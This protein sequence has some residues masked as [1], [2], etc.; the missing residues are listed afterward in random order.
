[1]KAVNHT[2]TTVK[3]KILEELNEDQQ[4]P[5]IDYHGPSFV[6]AG[7]G[8]GKTHTICS[9]A[10]YMIEEG[11]RPENMLIFT[12]TRKAAGELKE[13]IENKIGDK[14][15]GITIGTYHSV[16]SRL[17]RQYIHYLGFKNNFSIYDEEDK[18][19]LL[20]KIVTDDRIQHTTV[21]NYISDWKNRM[22]SPQ[23]AMV[24][25]QNTFEELSAGYYQKYQEQLKDQNALDF[26]DLIYQ[27]I[28]LLDNH[29]DVLEKVTNKYQYIMAE[30]IGR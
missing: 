2:L 28:R 27:T 11:V 21:A 5:V 7:P 20:K 6:L 24:N 19:N 22:I 13:R 30:L 15:Y 4:K 9:R 10:A 8:S 3:S 29:H 17:L 16:C 18:T 23:N 12:F 25:A 14:A 26:D 1:M